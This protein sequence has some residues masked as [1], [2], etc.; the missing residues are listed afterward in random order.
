MA[1]R[2]LPTG[3][4]CLG[5]F[6]AWH[7]RGVHHEYPARCD[8]LLLVRVATGWHVSQNKALGRALNVGAALDGDDVA[9][10]ACLH[11]LCAECSRP[12]SA[13]AE[14]TRRLL[15]RRYPAAQGRRTLSWSR[16]WLCA[17]RL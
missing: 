7:S 6:S 3:P 15:A 9:L 8:V 16:C 12:I 2:R 10:R 1:E 4:D 11:H 17:V 14:R 13:L 5:R